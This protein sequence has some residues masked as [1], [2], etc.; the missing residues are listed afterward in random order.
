[1]DSGDAAATSLQAP[2][3]SANLATNNQLLSHL[4]SQKLVPTTEP[5]Y[6]TCSGEATASPQPLVL[7]GGQLEE[8]VGDPAMPRR[9]CHPLYLEVHPIQASTGVRSHRLMRH[10]Q[11]PTKGAAETLKFNMTL[12]L[13][14]VFRNTITFLRSRTKLGVAIPFAE[15]LKFMIYTSNLIN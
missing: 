4:L 10:R 8:L 3:Q 9:L 15:T 14:S 13:L 7:H 12:I 1:M 6:P 5:K 11:C 2:G